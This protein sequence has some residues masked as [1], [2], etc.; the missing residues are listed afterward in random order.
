[1]QRTKKTRTIR[2]ARGAMMITGNLGST[3]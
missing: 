3:E 2:E 1:L